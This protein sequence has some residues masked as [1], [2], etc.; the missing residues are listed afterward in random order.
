MICKY[1]DCFGCAACVDICPKEAVKMEADTGFWRPVIDEAKCIHCELCKKACPA[2][3]LIN[4]KQTHYRESKCYAGWS[5]N[6]NRHFH[7]ASG[8]LASELSES[9]INKNGVVAGV[10]YDNQKREVRHILI[11]NTDGLRHI[12]KSK[13]VLSNKSG[14]YK[15]IKEKLEENVTCLFTGVPCEVNALHRYLKLSRT[16][17]DKLYTIDLLCRGGASPR[18]LKEHIDFVRKGND[19]SDITFRGGENDCKFTVWSL[20]GKPLYQ[21][22]QYVDA[23]FKYFMQHSLFQEKCYRC[24]FAGVHRQGDI[25]LGDFWGL[26]GTAA[27]ENDVS[28]VNLILINS[29]KGQRLYE[30][31][32][33]KIKVFERPMREAVEGNE[34]LCGATP[35]PPEYD[36]LW[37]VIS[38]KGFDSGLKEVYGTSESKNYWKNKYYCIKYKIKGEIMN[39]AKNIKNFVAV[40]RFI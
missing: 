18:C 9:V 26:K 5:K 20:N 11:E 34:T 31:V 25:T 21:G 2:L 17:T 36:A 27:E 13:Y 3:T 30:S 22:E 6:S 35:K 16:N 33:D 37:K 14:I 7:S 12:A 38:V 40:D 10:C 28:G 15:K 19:V 29:D 1:Q 4:N 39:I 8:G 24:P 32:R 23:Y